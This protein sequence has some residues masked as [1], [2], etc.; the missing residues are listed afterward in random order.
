MSQNKTVEEALRHGKLYLKEHHVGE[1][2]LDSQLLLM[3]ATDMTKVQLYTQKW[4]I[5][6]DE[7]TK[8]YDIY[9]R[10]RGEGK[11]T[12]YILGVCEFMGMDFMVEEGVLIPRPETEILVEAILEMAQKKV[13]HNI[14]DLGT[15]TGCIPISLAKYGG[16]H[17]WGVDIN[18]QALGLAARNARKNQV[19]NIVWIESDLYR[20]V[21]ENMHGRFDAV[22][23]NPPYIPT[24]EIPTLMQEVKNYEPHNAL[25]GGEDG[26]DFYRRIVR[27]AG[28]VLRE[29]G[30]LFFE[31]GATQEKSV[32]TILKEYRFD[33]IEV[34]QDL[35]GLSRVVLARKK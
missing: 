12:Q 15:G 6:T 30:W 28:D 7:E 14:L 20:K 2:A 34:R 21:P 10:E 3:K 18:R 33:S 16:M 27:G 4:K 22:V 35:A 32:V 9:L 5:L 1:Y 24:K 11:P 13:I 29:E 31:I 23:S 8:K 25:D 26:L 19:S 17:V